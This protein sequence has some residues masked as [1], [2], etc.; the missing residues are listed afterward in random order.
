M[1]DNVKK[2][3][4][5]VKRLFVLSAVC[6]LSILATALLPTAAKNERERATTKKTATRRTLPFP[7]SFFVF[8]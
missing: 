1:F 2:S 5:S 4:A 7:F 3:S 8:I 6:V